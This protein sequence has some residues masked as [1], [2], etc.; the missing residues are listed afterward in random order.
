MKV[1]NILV[2][3]GSDASAVKATCDRF[4]QGM[5]SEVINIGGRGSRFWEK[6]LDEVRSNR[7]KYFMVLVGRRDFDEEYFKLIDS[8]PN[9]TAC[10][11]PKANVRNATLGELMKYIGICKSKFRLALSIK[12]SLL[13]PKVSE[14]EV[15]NKDL[16]NPAYDNFLVINEGIRIIEKLTN[17]EVLGDAILA[18]REFAGLH[19]MFG[20]N[21]YELLRMR[22]S[23]ESLRPKV[24]YVANDELLR[25][26]DL[27]NTIIKS[28][29]VLN[30]YEGISISFIRELSK[31]FD[32]VVVPWSGGKDSTAT[33]LITVKALGK[34]GVDV[35][36]VDTGVEFHYTK[37]YIEKVAKLLG[38]DYK[39]FRA[40]VREE[41][42]KGKELPTHD[43]RWCTYLKRLAIANYIRSKF[44]GRKVLVVIG[45]R[46]AESISRSR[47]GF[48]EGDRDITNA[49]NAYPIKLWGGTHVQLYLMSRG[50]NLCKLYNLGF[51][52]V[53]CY[54]C[55][56]LRSWEIFII[57]NTEI[58]KSLINNPLWSK[59]LKS[60]KG[61]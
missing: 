32:E 27:I 16:I 51:Y 45:D 46:D 44:R 42:L 14:D 56:S 5:I 4:F 6:V 2:R 10:L 57:L 7:N 55:P 38:I 1:I 23:E 60:R 20:F 8:L 21:G 25:G 24:E 54:I 61:T 13:L 30:I 39:V 49:V 47:K 50:I 34:H 41:L 35:V 33:L 36:Y 43:N 58:G 28:S 29:N 18:F 22:F 48:V 15:V 12:N 9:V 19:T 40:P 59:F 53:G 17:K 26:I 37:E 31:E 52:R 11:I 3:G